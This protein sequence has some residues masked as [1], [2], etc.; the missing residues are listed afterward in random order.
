MISLNGFVAM[1]LKNFHLQ[2][3]LAPTELPRYEYPL[4][5]ILPR[6]S[7]HADFPL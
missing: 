6:R 7:R 5:N 3:A 1:R 4:L 2:Q